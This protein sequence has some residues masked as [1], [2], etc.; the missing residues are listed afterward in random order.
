MIYSILNGLTLSTIFI[1]YDAGTV[2]L[3]FIASSL[4]FGVMAIYGKITKKD[5]TSMGSV[6]FMLLIGLII[7][8]VVNMFLGNSTLDFILAAG[9]ATIF[10]GLTAWDMQKL[11]QYYYS[12]GDSEALG[13]I[14]IMGAL[15]LYLDFINIFLSLLRV[16]GGSRD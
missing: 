16:F 11:K 14:A 3:A 5:L 7:A 10:A 9:G 1:I 6:M 8:Y 15:S 13:S 2:S 12:Y 4:L